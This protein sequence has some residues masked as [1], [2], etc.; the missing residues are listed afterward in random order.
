MLF[1][2]Q[3]E[4]TLGIVIGKMRLAIIGK[5]SRAISI[6]AVCHIVARFGRLDTFV[7]PLAEV[8]RPV[9]G[10]GFLEGLGNRYLPHVFL[11]RFHGRK[12]CVTKSTGSHAV[13]QTVARRCAQGRRRVAR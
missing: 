6:R 13:Q 10:I 7:V 4:D 5:V 3:R 2:S 8:S 12:N 1:I 11:F 9:F